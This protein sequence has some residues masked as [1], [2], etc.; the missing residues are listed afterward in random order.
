NSNVLSLRLSTM[1]PSKDSTPDKNSS[2]QFKD[3]REFIEEIVSITPDL[4]TI[5]ETE[6]NRIIYTS[7]ES[8][9]QGMFSP[10]EMNEMKGQIAAM[11]HADD[12]EKAN[13]F[14]WERR[15]L[16]GNEV[17]EAELKT[18]QNKWIRVRSKVFK[19]DEQGV[20]LQ[21]RKS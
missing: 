9:L 1:A 6:S 18:R 2:D 21:D 13:I 19:R 5:C 10:A 8:F 17:K 7:N 11:I 12:L 16:K 4:I 14:M 20:A 3:S 15:L